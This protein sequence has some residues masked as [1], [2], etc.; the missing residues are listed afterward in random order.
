MR[1]RPIQNPIAHPSA[2]ASEPATYPPSGERQIAWPY[3]KKAPPTV[4]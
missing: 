1:E 4:T 3:P 2:R